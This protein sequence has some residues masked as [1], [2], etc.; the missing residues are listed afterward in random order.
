MFIETSSKQNYSKP[1]RGSMGRSGEAHAA[2]MG[3]EA[4]IRGTVSLNVP[5]LAELGRA[6]GVVVAI[7]MPL[8]AELGRFPA[9]EMVVSRTQS[10]PETGASLQTSPSAAPHQTSS[11]VV[12][13]CRWW[14]PAL[15]LAY[16]PGHNFIMNLTLMGRLGGCLAQLHVCA[17]ISNIMDFFPC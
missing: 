14:S 3:L 8:P 12:L 11:T 6:P 7:N 13:A 16:G 2:P 15:D 5:L 10:R 17:S 9:L 4:I 1:H